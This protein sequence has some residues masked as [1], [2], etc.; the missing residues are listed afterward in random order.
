MIAIYPA[1]MAANDVLSR[2]ELKILGSI[3]KQV[4]S[5]KKIAKDIS[6][7]PLTTSQLIT[8]LMTKG[9]IE[10]ILSKGTIRRYSY[11]EKFAITQ[12]G[13]AIL[14]EFNRRNSPWNQLRDLLR[15]ESSEFPLKITIGAVMIG[16]R[17]AKFVLK[18]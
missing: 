2:W 3:E 7:N 18:A 15:Q 12:E 6:L 10:R 5:E 8:G 16:Y 17:L 9:Y 11:T 4:K 13:L 14:E 1:A